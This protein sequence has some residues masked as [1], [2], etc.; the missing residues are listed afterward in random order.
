MNNQSEQE[1]ETAVLDIIEAH[2]K[3]TDNSLMPLNAT[4]RIMQLITQH[5]EQKVLEAR[6]DE[7]QYLDD[8]YQENSQDWEREHP[9]YST[10]MI[11]MED[12]INRKKELET[13]L[14]KLKE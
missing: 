13:Q 14:N 11:P 7:I 4:K 1:L 9:G 5:T 10:A 8:E 6:I 3:P 2:F 12:Y